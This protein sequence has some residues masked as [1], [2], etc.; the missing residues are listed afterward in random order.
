MTTQDRATLKRYFAA[1]AR[2]TEEQF[3]SLID[4]ALIMDDE[5]FRKT[6]D[7]GLR[8]VT[9][10][11]SK[12]LLSFQRPASV[13]ADWS[14]GFPNNQGDRLLVKRG[15][16][17]ST[18][19]LDP[20]VLSLAAA[21]AAPRVRIG[22]SDA[23]Q[24]AELDVVG[25]ISSDGRMGRACQSVLADG[26][27]HDITGVLSGCVAFEVMAGVGL[28]GTGR[29]AL[30]HAVAMNTYNPAWWENLFGLKKP[31]RCQHAY[32]ARASDRLQLRWDPRPKGAS[33]PPPGS[34]PGGLA[35]LEDT[36]F[37]WAGD[38]N[39]KFGRDS[40]YVLQI[41]T[42]SS[43]AD[44]QQPTPPIKAFVTRLWYDSMMLAPAPAPAGQGSAR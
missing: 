5:G 31:I 30:L 43:Y 37:G 15:P 21:G 38:V 20:T 11:E 27:Y 17:Q 10:G 1:G 12:A 18:T 23:P 14:I 9:A 29:F 42:R 28:P 25:A 22:A 32:Y 39:A 7:D 36:L 13:R 33:P 26:D 3:A 41:K 19:P 44:P 2:P 34:E 24:A 35:K 4:S 16:L 8:I 40:H 6:L